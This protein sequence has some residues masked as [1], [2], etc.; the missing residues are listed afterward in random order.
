MQRDAA[1]LILNNPERKSCKARLLDLP[2]MGIGVQPIITHH[3]LTLIR[4]MGGQ[5]ND[6]RACHTVHA[7][8]LLPA[9][10][11]STATFVQRDCLRDMS[12]QAIRGGQVI[13]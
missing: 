6:P 7:W 10:C 3:D 12:S 2:P 13:M 1:E 8:L 4:D 9:Y 5:C 11:N